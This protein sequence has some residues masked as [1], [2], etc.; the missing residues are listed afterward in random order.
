MSL[1]TLSML[2]A[3]AFGI[4]LLVGLFLVLARVY[5]AGLVLAGT[6]AGLSWA[7]YFLLRHTR[8]RSN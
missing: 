3:P 2:M 6:G 5:T 1:R 7:N 4:I 8:P